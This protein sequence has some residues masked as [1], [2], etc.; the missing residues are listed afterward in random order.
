MKDDPIITA[1]REVRHRISES[2]GHDPKKLIE[3][4][5]Q[6]QRRHRNRLVSESADKRQ[7]E[8]LAGQSNPPEF[9]SRGITT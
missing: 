8:N 5:K 6:L 3:Y 4:Y 2:V 7:R 1:L 9:A